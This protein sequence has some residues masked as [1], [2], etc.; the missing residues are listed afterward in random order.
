MA[1]GSKGRGSEEVLGDRAA[2]LFPF[3]LRP[4]QNLPGSFSPPVPHQGAPCAP[5]NPTGNAAASSILYFKCSS[6]S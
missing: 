3:P 2:T 5:S 6:A 4:S 1:L